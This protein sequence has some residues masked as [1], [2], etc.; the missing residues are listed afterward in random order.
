MDSSYNVLVT[1]AAGHLGT[2]LMLALPEHGF[3]PFG[4]DLLASPTTTAVGSITD[5]AFIRSLLQGS[6]I[7]HIIHAAALHKPHVGSHT[8]AQFIDTNITGTLVLLEAAAEV[9]GQQQLASFLFLSTTSAFGSALAPAAGQPAAWI[10]EAVVPRPKNIYGVT[11]VAAEDLCWL[12]HTQA[13]LPI[14]VLRTSRFFPEPDDD[15]HRRAALADANL[16][17]L[18]LAHRRVDLDDVV[19]ACVCGMARARA[20]GW[21]RYVIS[22]PPPFARDEATLAGLDGDA[23]A[24]VRRVVPAVEAVFAARGWGY[25]PRIDRVY[26]SAKAVREL[27]W[28]PRYTFAD[29]VAM[30]REGRVWQSALTARVGSKGYH[31]ESTGVYT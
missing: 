4:I 25:L 7:A 10:D 11:K 9:L 5:R 16:K 30:V 18:E 29:A 28:R 2:A 21:G 17:L 14:L 24:V 13:A 26:D 22:A 20:L 1:G 12:V 6:R 19:A 15:A 23:A 31:A 3:T 8:K 27:G